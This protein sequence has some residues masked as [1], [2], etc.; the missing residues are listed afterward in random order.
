MSEYDNDVI[1]SPPRLNASFEYLSFI[2][3]FDFI[4]AG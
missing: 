2:F 4:F 3:Y 1:L